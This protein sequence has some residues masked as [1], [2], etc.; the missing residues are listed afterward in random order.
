MTT[1]VIFITLSCSPLYL[2]L[3]PLYPSPFSSY[4]FLILIVGGGAPAP[5]APSGP[6]VP[7]ATNIP[8]P[9]MSK[10]MPPL[11]PPG[12]PGG[13]MP[14]LPPPGPPANA[15]PPPPPPGIYFLF[16]ILCLLNYYYYHYCAFILIVA[17]RCTSGSST[18]FCR[19]E[20]NS[21]SPSCSRYFFGI[22]YYSYYQLM[23]CLQPSRS[24]IQEQVLPPW[25]LTASKKLWMIL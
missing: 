12:P 6:P 24:L 2:S 18:S 21:S 10:K 15:P 25:M 19:F 3:P 13:K 5:A 7:M 23:V 22:M 14:P 17:H 8:P 1:M 16:T 11:P 9:P 4:L 20:W